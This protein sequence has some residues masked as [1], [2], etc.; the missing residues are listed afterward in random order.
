MGVLFG[1]MA[2]QI[3]TKRHRKPTLRINVQEY[4]HST[5]AYQGL[6][7]F[8]VSLGSKSQIRAWMAKFEELMKGMNDEN[9]E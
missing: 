3:V 5:K 6:T 1:R 4:N 2:H 9:P 7:S 8:L